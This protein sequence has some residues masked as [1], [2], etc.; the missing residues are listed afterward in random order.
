MINKEESEKLF[1]FISSDIYLSGRYL[2]LLNKL[3]KMIS[4]KGHLL[5]EAMRSYGSC[6]VIKCNLRYFRNVNEKG[7]QL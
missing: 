4:G 7:C 5:D 6:K 3:K 1:K 2:V